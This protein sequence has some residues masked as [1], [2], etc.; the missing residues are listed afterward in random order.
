M[1]ITKN[2]HPHDFYHNERCS[3]GCVV[4]TG[5]NG[6]PDLVA[7]IYVVYPRDGAGT[8]W[9]G[10][11]DYDHPDGIKCYTQSAGGYGY[12]KLTAAL[13]GTTIGGI[14]LGNHCDSRRRPL[15]DDVCAANGWLLVEP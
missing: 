12:D 7:R 6:K 10:V 4:K 15:I 9:V 14:E 5:S 2:T 11:M 13:S 1:R 8:L 3:R